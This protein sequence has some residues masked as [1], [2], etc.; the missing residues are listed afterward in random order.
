LSEKKYTAAAV[1]PKIESFLKN[2]LAKGGFQLSF[3]ITDGAA[4]HPDFE[5]P[6]VWVKFSGGDLEYLLANKAELLLALEQITMEML[7][8]PGEDHTLLCFDANDYR[9]LRVEE[10]RLSALTAAERVKKTH[11]PFHFSPMTS[12]ERRIL[13][14]AL[15]NDAAVRSE[16]LGVG[17][18]RQVVVYPADMPSLPEPPR[19]VGG[20]PRAGG[21]QR[22]SGGGPPRGSGGPP[23]GRARRGRS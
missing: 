4:P 18:G 5:N 6:D 21:P 11:A 22:G 20:M 16:S 17:P 10:L 15:R 8:M 12:R 9:M 2:I 13:H 7:H 3:Q 14:L 23:R 1:G 19:P